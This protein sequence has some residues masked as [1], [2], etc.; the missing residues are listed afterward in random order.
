M[1]PT[2]GSYEGEGIA[3]RRAQRELTERV[4]VPLVRRS[5]S[6]N[7][8]WSTWRWRLGIRRRAQAEA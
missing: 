4:A 1:S 2:T 3:E 6:N 5:K 8:R 7:L